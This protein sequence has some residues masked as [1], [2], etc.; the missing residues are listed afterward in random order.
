MKNFDQMFP[1]DSNLINDGVW[2]DV[3]VGA[4]KKPSRLF[5]YRL[6]DKQFQG[7]R[8]T[9]KKQN[10]FAIKQDMLSAEDL[11]RKT[12]PGVARYILRGWENFPPDKPADYSVELAETM[13]LERMS[14][15]VGVMQ[16]AA[17]TEA[18]IKEDL[19]DAGK[20]LSTTSSGTESG[21][22]TG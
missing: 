5:I 18:F 17:N 22:S 14:F 10:D 19:K 16:M 11:A 20:P 21:A 4:N 7:F 9:I 15:Y 2:F 13:M 1:K 12:I 8:E 6:D 3:G